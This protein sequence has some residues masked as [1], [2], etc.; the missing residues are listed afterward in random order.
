MNYYKIT[1]IEFDFDDEDLT[2]DEQNEIIQESTNFLWT[3]P[4]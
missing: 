4:T 2:V 3:S 1:D